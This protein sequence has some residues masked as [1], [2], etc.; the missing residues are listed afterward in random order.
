MKDG[1]DP[2]A[3]VSAAYLNQIELER[4]GD[5]G[6]VAQT[7]LGFAAKV[8]ASIC[9]SAARKL[10][11]VLRA[12][13]SVLTEQLLNT[14]LQGAKLNVETYAYCVSADLQRLGKQID[15][16]FD[17]QAKIDFFIEG[18]R[19]ARDASSRDKVLRLAQVVVS[20][21]VSDDDGEEKV[22]EFIRFASELNETDIQVL[23]EVH[24]FQSKLNPKFKDHWAQGVRRAMNN[25]VLLDVN[26]QPFDDQTVR[27]ACARLQALGLVGQ[28]GGTVSDT[29]PGE[30]PYAVLDLGREFLS[31]LM[32]QGTNA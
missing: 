13:L 22:I 10:P 19:R 15:D 8:G 14:A 30:T 5:V 24:S 17:S 1:L 32:Q 29:S 3:S 6:P 21:V 12:P 7:I 27:S 25:S 4:L 26:R 28:I 20:G 31:Y 9:S 18:A 23:K 11:E 2:L 16:L